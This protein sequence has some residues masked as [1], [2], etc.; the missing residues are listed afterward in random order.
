MYMYITAGTYSYL[1]KLEEQ[2][3]SE[4]MMLMQN[5]RTVELWHETDKNTLFQSPRK[6]ETIDTL[7]HFASEGFIACHYVPV[8]DENRPLFEYN[9]ENKLSLIEKEEGL[10]AGRILRPLSS[11]VY[12]IM[13]MWQSERNYVRWEKSSTFTKFQIHHHLGNI[14]SN[15]PHTYTFT[16]SEE[17]LEED[18]FNPESS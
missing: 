8:R 6:Y 3:P 11:E 9:F 13:T 4:K 5:I 18:S 16:V 14:F 15:T 17:E 1:K 12:I 10:L 2:H 7:G